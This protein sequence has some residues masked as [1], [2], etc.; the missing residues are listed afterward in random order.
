MTFVEYKQLNPFQRFAYNFKK[1]ICN[2][3][4]AVANFFKALGRGIVKFFV[5]IGKGL[6]LI[7]ISEP[8]RPY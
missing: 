5:G 8:T 2:V 1:F 3:P 4:H 7:H 6:S